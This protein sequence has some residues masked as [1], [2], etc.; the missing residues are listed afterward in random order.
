MTR[1]KKLFDGSIGAILMSIII[2]FILGAVVLFLAG[3]NPVQAYGALFNGIF[4]RPRYIAQ[5]IITATP[6]IITGIS[7]TFAYKTG[8]FNIG[9]DGQ[10]MIG[11]VAAAFIG[12]FVELPPI[13]HPIV[14]II[15]AMIAAGLYG[16]LVGFLKA[17]Y[18]I[19][20]VLT[21]I[22]LNWI[23][24]YFNNFYINIPGVKK[25]N[26]EA[27]YEVL[28]TAYITVMQNL[29]TTP[30]G[31]EK[32]QTMPFADI[33]MRT[34][35]NYGIIIAIICAIVVWYILGKTTLGYSL[36]AVGSNRDAAEFAGI[37]VKRNIM[38]S[39]A[40]SGA[41]AGLAGAI[42]IMGMSPH[43]VVTLALSENYGF[44]GLSVA[45]IANLNPIGC[46][47]SGL[48]FGGLKYGGGFIQTEMGAPSEIINIVIG[49]IVFFISMSGIFSVIK[50][51][52]V[53]RGEVNHES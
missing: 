38:L 21:S 33:I 44:N 53:K 46:I 32:I 16:S 10:F 11:A 3:Y 18:G 17:K 15:G 6:I 9:A 8:L 51:F 4:G 43:R 41:I 50:K 26:T 35:L 49:V 40:I 22:M 45:L 12:Y 36:K 30:E 29:K 2:G 42:Y 7:V 14:V 19:N 48:L 13:I 24:L 47:F 25:P 34:D 31:V 23:A 37:N 5:T 27:S 20:E 52:F 39:M 28:Q 1:I